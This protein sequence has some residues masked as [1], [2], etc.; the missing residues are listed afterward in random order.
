MAQKHEKMFQGNQAQY[1]DGGSVNWKTI[2]HYLVKLNM[3]IPYNP[4]VTLLDMQTKQTL[5]RLHQ[6]PC[7]GMFIAVLANVHQ[8]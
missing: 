8:L 4:T 6:R 5:A 1:T 3:G 2:W 7:S